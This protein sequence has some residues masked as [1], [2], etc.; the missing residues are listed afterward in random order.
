MSRRRTIIA[1]P[2]AALA[3]LAFFVVA[4]IGVASAQDE[5]ITSATPDIIRSLRE[6]AQR[7]LQYA[8]QQM[9]RAASW[10]EL[11]RD[12]RRNAHSSAAP[13]DQK[14]WLDSAAL[15]DRYALEIEQNVAKLRARAEAADARAARLEAAVR[16]RDG[17]NPRPV[18]QPPTPA[19]VPAPTPAAQTPPAVPTPPPPRQASAP[20]NELARFLLGR[21]QKDPVSETYPEVEIS[22][23]AD[24]KLRF[25]GEHDDWIGDYTPASDTMPARLTFTR[26]PTAEEMSPKAPEWAR[27]AVAGKLEWRLELDVFECPDLQLIGKW[28]PGE[29]RWSERGGARDASVAGRGE[30]RDYTFVRTETEAEA[31]AEVE[32]APVLLIASPRAPLARGGLKSVIKKRGFLPVMRTSAAWARANGNS[33]K[34]VLR[35]KSGKTAEVE[36]VRFGSA[37][38]M[39]VVYMPL[40]PVIIDDHDAAP[41]IIGTPLN[42]KLSQETVRLEVEDGEVVT[43]E[44][45]GASVSFIVFD[46]WVQQGIA[47]H[48]RNFEQLNK[49]FL[50]IIEDSVSTR[51]TKELALQKSRLIQNFEKFLAYQ[52]QG[53]ENYTDYTRLEIGN[54]YERLLTGFGDTDPNGRK[55]VLLRGPPPDRYGVSY[56]TD[57]EKQAV[58]DAMAA[59][60]KR[61]VEALGFM[62]TELLIGTYDF[63]ANMTG[64]AQFVA[65]VWEIDPHGNPVDATDRLFAGIGLASQLLLVGAATAGQVSRLSKETRL[66]DS[67]AELLQ[68]DMIAA[69]QKMAGV[70][71]KGLPGQALQA[72]PR[73]GAT[74]PALIPGKAANM[75]DNI[76]DQVL[77][78]TLDKIYEP[79]RL[80]ARHNTA[81]EPLHPGEKT[82][83]APVEAAPLNSGGTPMQ[84]GS[85]ACG[86]AVAEGGM[87]DA[88]YVAIAERENL[89][90]AARNNNF[91][92]IEVTPGT[93]NFRGGGMTSVQLS[94][95][96]WE[97]GAITRIA[98]NLQKN[99]KLFG[100]LNKG[101]REGKQ[102]YLMVNN[103]TTAKPN[104]HWV[105]FEGF[106]CQNGKA[107]A[108]IGDPWRGASFKMS[109]RMLELRIHE[110]VE[111]DWSSLQA[112]LGGAR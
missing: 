101:L 21:Y 79:H 111:A 6:E 37:N 103:G 7:D 35:S 75:A 10:R 72:S 20:D 90:V 61:Y 67:W 50:S 96:L 3:A 74:S 12:A 56:L 95:H 4:A 53:N 49:F 15:Y 17:D 85:G 91:E 54:A 23:D 33:A 52:A 81:W 19:P 100:R 38:V 108:H 65:A 25:G 11:E 105:R 31:W 48:R 47:Y 106:S 46:S 93:P 42:V 76:V 109:P 13:A 32:A 59:A 2:L 73:P 26:K 60:Y 24:G 36:L 34:L 92:P 1:A 5:A 98:D 84:I 41:L 94:R 9:A 22:L 44:I 51:E 70:Q 99:A 78:K 112:A 28:Y 88:G 107:F 30:P 57:L 66:A 82:F 102:Y 45:A 71:P 27:Q 43:A 83:E 89:R 80:R 86:L 18:A 64:A 69:Q 77:D 40:E 58:N 110:V 16:Q 39:P 97:H 68:R 55:A 63:I 14:M 62:G 29:L 8:D 87:R 104:Y